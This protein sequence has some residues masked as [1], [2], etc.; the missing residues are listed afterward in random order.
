MLNIHEI[1]S[2]PK[3]ELH[4]HLNGLIETTVI[5]E[6]LRS[7]AAEEIGTVDLEN[8]LRRVAPC[9][10]LE[11]YLADW[12]LLR[13]IP[14]SRSSLKLMVS[15]AFKQLKEQNILFAE[16]RSSVIY[17]ALLNEIRVAE[18]LQWL[19][20][21]VEIAS[22][23]YSISAGIIMTVTR[24]DYS[25]E[26][27]RA[28][29]TAF[30]QLGRPKSVIGVDLAG[31]EEDSCPPELSSLFMSAKDYHDLKVTIHAGETGRVENIRQAIME[32]G[33]DRIGHGTAAGKCEE[34]M[35]LLRDRDICLEVCPISN[36]MTGAV[37]ANEA[38]PLSRF[39]QHDVPFVICS[40][41][42]SL[43][44]SNLNADYLEF[45]KES[46]RPELIAEMYSLQKKYSFLKFTE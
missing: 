21:E 9:T 32:F 44:K 18:A 27:I 24:G 7:E 12:N 40:D 26:N 38:H 2:L 8:S 1:K 46:G 41:N 43:H 10:S 20:E 22:K 39:I 31:I 36:R 11:E 45:L 19:I 35:A 33:A 14:R 23:F 17:I 13:M 37:P 6:L 25:V 15:S 3:G 30:H 28:L 34:T 4:V 5:I 42:P 16:I 29:L